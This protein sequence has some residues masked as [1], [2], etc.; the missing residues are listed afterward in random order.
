MDVHR[1][2]G[3]CAAVMC[4]IGTVLADDPLLTVRNSNDSA[5]A[6]AQRMKHE[7]SRI[8]VDSY[9][10]TP[11]ESRLVKSARDVPL[12]IAGIAGGDD[13]AGGES[14]RAKL[15]DKGAITVECAERTG[16]VDLNDLA[17]KLC[18]RGIDSILLEGGG[19]LAWSALEAGIVD[20]VR[21]Y[22]APIIIGG[23]AAPGPFGGI[24]TELLAD[25]FRLENIVTEK[26]G[27]DLVI[28]GRVCSRD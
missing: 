27:D 9:F 18:I 24:G 22:V 6:R 16:Q 2:R 25:A 4:G 26:I 28:E 17:A 5:Q 20:R 12:I 11:V 10:R 7:P 8:V 13:H 14:A 19:R 3:E 15:E 21:L 23:N 1:L